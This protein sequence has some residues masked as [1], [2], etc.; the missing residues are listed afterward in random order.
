MTHTAPSPT[1]PDLRCLPL[2]DASGLALDLMDWGATWLSCRVP[3]PG[4]AAPREVL[5]GGPSPVAHRANTAYLGA[6]VGRY[7]NR[8]AG[9]CIER[10]GQVWPLTPQPGSAHQLHGGPDGFSQ[11]RWAVL[12]HG[13][14]H[15]CFALVSPDGDQGVI[16]QHFEARCSAATPVGLTNHAYFNLDGDASDIRRHQL[17][18]PASRYLPVDEALIPLGPLAP[19]A[20]TPFDFRLLRPIAAGDAPDAGAYDH[21]FLL[22]GAAEPARPEGDSA[23]ALALQTAAELLASDGRLR[24][25]IETSMAALQVYT[26]A[27]LGSQTGRDGRP[28]NAHAGVALEPQCL[29]DSPHHPEWPQP[30]CWLRPGQ[31]WAQRIRYRFSAG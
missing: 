21:A 24:L 15:V 18:V 22:D 16:E 30:G 7:A 23:R 14:D 5:L 3:V 8:I 4:E 29:P 9:S 11:R 12:E 25:T 2:R 6:T 1:D 31:V 17:R 10:E 26:G 28:M 19:V 13:P 20:G 27:Y